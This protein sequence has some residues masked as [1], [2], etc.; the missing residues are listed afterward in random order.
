MKGKIARAITLD[1]FITY[2]HGT[3]TEIFKTEKRAPIHKSYHNTT[4]YKK[5]IRTKLGEPYLQEIISAY[6]N[7]K[8]YLSIL[9]SFYVHF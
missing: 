8:K 6:E 2:Q 7:F 5:L 1:S 9:I 3:L 4:I